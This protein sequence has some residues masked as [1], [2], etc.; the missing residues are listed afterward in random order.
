MHYLKK[1]CLW[2]YL[3]NDYEY[4]YRVAFEKKTT[5]VQQSETCVEDG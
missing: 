1:P 4:V 3:Y 5:D 2:Q